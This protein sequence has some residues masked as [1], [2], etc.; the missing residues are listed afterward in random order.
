MLGEATWK[1][2]EQSL[3]RNS[4]PSALLRSWKTATVKDLEDARKVIPSTSTF[5]SPI[6]MM[7]KT[8]GSWRMAV[9][10]HQLNQVVTVIAAVVPDMVSLLEQINTFF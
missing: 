3:P 4:K 1:P 2:I 6:W 7:R 5:S 8:D 9:D 10:Y